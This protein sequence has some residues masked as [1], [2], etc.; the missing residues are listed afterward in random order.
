MRFLIAAVFAVFVSLMSPVAS[1]AIAGDLA[2][3]AQIFSGNCAACHIGGNN[4]VMAQKTL[5]VDALEQYLDGYGTEHDINAIIKQVTYGKN[6]MA[7]FG[8]R[9]SEDEIV[10]VAAYVQDQADKGW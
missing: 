2:A 5:K 6:A 8:T 4:A 3:G 9:L 1:P 7:A 10:N